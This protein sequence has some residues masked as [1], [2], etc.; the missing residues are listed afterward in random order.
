MVPQ[1]VTTLSPGMR[2]L[3][4]PNFRSRWTAKGSS[5]RNEPLSK[6]VSIRS[7]AVIL[8]LA[9]CLAIRSSP[10]P[11][12]DSCLSWCNFSI[13]GFIVLSIVLCPAFSIFIHNTRSRPFEIGSRFAPV[14]R[15]NSEKYYQ[16]HKT[17]YVQANSVSTFRDTNKKAKQDQFIKYI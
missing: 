15:V 12:F 9:R 7:C 10:P 16:S 6:S 11:I 14:Q 13:L 1:P 17:K 4:M 3:S 2:C 8:P 5:S